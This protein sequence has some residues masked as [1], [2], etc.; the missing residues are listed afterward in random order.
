VH[1]VGL[2]EVARIQARYQSD[3]M[4]PLGFNGTFEAF[5][6]ECKEDPKF[7]F[8]SAE[9]LLQA[10]RTMCDHIGSVLPQYFDKFPESA[11]QIVPKDAA[12]AP[13]AYYLAGTADGSRP[14]RFYVNVSNLSQRPS[15]EMC[16][17]ALH[18]AIPGH[19]HQCSLAIENKSIPNFLRYIEDRR[20]EFCPAR[21]QLYA[22]YLEGWALYCEA[23]G[24]EMGIYTDPMSIF[25]RLSMEM[26]RAVRL[27]VDT[28]IHAQGWS[29]E[30]AITY[31]ME[32]SGMHRH[33]CEAECY[34]YE[35]WPGQACAYKVGEVAIWRARRKA[36]AELGPQFDLKQFHNVLLDSGGV[37]LDALKDMVDEWILQVKA[38]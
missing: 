31:M 36:E 15:Y 23:L 19:H 33:E 25:G 7:Y 20:Y 27:V 22:A 34:R 17:L 11:L 16:A 6:A 37:P 24:E 12:S 18:E 10:Y 29:V 32:K 21:R 26:M 35:A 3:V 2:A 38:Q 5:V 28:G 1:Q 30:Q 9:A 8:D 13:A 4:N 14:G